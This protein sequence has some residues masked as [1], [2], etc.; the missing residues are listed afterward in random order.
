MA[1][2][3]YTTVDEFKNYIG[4]SGNVS[5]GDDDMIGSLLSA[6]EFKTDQFCNREETGFLASDTATDRFYVGDGSAVCWIDDCVEITEV[7]VKANYNEASYNTWSSSDWLAASGF[8][9]QADFNQTP[10][11]FILTNITG[12]KTCFTT[13]KL[14]QYQSVPT[15]KVTAK[16]GY[17]LS[18]SRVMDLVK[19]AVLAQAMRWHARY[20]SKWAD[21]AAGPD[22]GV[23]LY[24]QSLDPDIKDMLVNG[25]LVKDPLAHGNAF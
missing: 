20:S 21:T 6:A 8:P 9:R 14:G 19:S 15:V 17:A 11:T 7:A 12:G 22:S 23:L 10:Y 4:R 3:V 13:G 2:P 24:R 5:K 16:W 18:T 25:G 1:D